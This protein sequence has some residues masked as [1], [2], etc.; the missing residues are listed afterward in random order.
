MGRE[1]G[2][3]M[4]SSLLIDEPKTYSRWWTFVPVIPANRDDHSY[5]TLKRQWFDHTMNCVESVAA[6][7][8]LKSSRGFYVEHREDHIA[9]VL[10][11]IWAAFPDV[12]WVGRLLDLWSVQHGEVRRARWSYSWE[13]REGTKNNIT[14][15]VLSWE[16]AEGEAVLVIEAKRPGGQ[17]SDK[18]RNGGACYLDMASVRPFRRKQMVYLVDERDAPRIRG[19]LPASIPVASFQAM[20]QLQADLIGR[21]H[22]DVGHLL[23]ACVGRHYAELGMPFDAHLTRKLAGID[24]T[25]RQ[26]RYEAVFDLHLPDPIERFLVGA[27]VTFCARAGRMPAAPYP[28]LVDEPSLPEVCAAKVQTTYDRSKPLWRLPTVG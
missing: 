15:I 3:I 18:D 12:A 21:C 2:V 20:G 27:E 16:D 13:Q 10:F 22:G 4:E 17:L 14:D 11:H 19:G 6:R 23:R 9:T 8:K 24:F 26:R 7:W 1:G 28:W 5:H 25:G